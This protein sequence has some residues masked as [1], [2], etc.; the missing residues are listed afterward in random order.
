MVIK[1]EVNPRARRNSTQIMKPDQLVYK[2]KSGVRNRVEQTLDK[3]EYMV[4]ED[5]K[6]DVKEKDIHKRK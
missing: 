4:L 3:D 2:K 1:K 6:R 5:L